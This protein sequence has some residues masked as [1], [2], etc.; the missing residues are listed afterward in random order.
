VYIAPTARI[1][2]IPISMSRN[3]PTCPVDRQ[4]RNPWLDRN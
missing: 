1:M 2:R 4:R 3:R